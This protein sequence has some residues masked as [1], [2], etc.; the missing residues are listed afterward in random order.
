MSI[1]KFLIEL[2][3]TDQPTIVNSANQF[4][5]RFYP[6]GVDPEKSKSQYFLPM[7][8]RQLDTFLDYE[9]L[10]KFRIDS[11]Q[12][13]C[14][15]PYREKPENADNINRLKYFRWVCLSYLNKQS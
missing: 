8:E 13:Y 4:I 10:K 12:Y 6:N 7:V 1:E 5:E 15:P 11:S 9:T 14:Y 2:G 3:I